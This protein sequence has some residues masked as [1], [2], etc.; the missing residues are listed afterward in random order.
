MMS[1]EDIKCGNLLDHT[2][3]SKKKAIAVILFLDFLKPKV[4]VHLKEERE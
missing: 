1:R 2:V 4:I 3:Q